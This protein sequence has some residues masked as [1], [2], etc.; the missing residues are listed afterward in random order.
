MD[1]AFKDRDPIHGRLPEQKTIDALRRSMD[2]MN[3]AELFALA[4]SCRLEDPG[5]G[6]QTREMFDE[7]RLCGRLGV[8]RHIIEQMPNLKAKDIEVFLTDVRV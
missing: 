8:M 4:L 1:K 6:R 5:I 3:D 2:R 7:W